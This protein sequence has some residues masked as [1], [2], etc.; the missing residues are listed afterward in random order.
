M[1]T[2]ALA[3]G[4]RDDLPRVALGRREAAGKPRSG[5]RSP[6]RSPVRARRV[7]APCRRA[8]LRPVWRCRPPPGKRLRHPP[9][10]D[11]DPQLQAVPAGLVLG[12]S[13]AVAPW[14]SPHVPG[15]RKV[16][17]QCF[18]A[19]RPSAILAATSTALS[20][21]CASNDFTC[22]RRPH[23]G[24]SICPNAISQYPSAPLRWPNGQ[25]SREAG[26]QSHGPAG[27]GPPNRGGCRCGRPGCR[28][29]DGR[30]HPVGQGGT[31]RPDGADERPAVEAPLR[32]LALPVRPG[33]P[34]G[35]TGS[36]GCRARA[37]PAERTLDPQHGATQ[38]DPEAPG[39]LHRVC[40]RRAGSVAPER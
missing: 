20:N 34:V 31:A 37:S 17:L 2:S 40:R 16:S 11:P 23:G 32:V 30:V 5:P 38:R 27:H 8:R 36:L 28:A 26:T 14:G 35:R 19:A 39:A 21:P 6:A 9:L 33:A 1:S 24:G 22:A 12:P 25:T 29:I 18:G 4:A 3:R 10:L 15:C 7:R 13:K